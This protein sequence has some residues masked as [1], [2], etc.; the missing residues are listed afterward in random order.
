MWPLLIY[1]S[2]SINVTKELLVFIIHM[3]PP[4]AGF[5][6]DHTRY[7]YSDL[8]ENVRQSADSDVN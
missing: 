7:D 2:V 1:W 6:S 5:Y 3:C 4:C 8:S